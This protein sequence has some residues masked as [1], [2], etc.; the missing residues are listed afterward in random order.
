MGHPS[1]AASTTL[2][3]TLN[4]PILRLAIGDL[5]KFGLRRPAKGPMAQVVESRKIPL[6]DIGTVD[7]IRRRMVAV[8]PGIKRISGANVHFDDG[9]H[10]A[11]DIIIQATGYRPNLRPLLP[12]HQDVLDRSGGP[13]TCGN[14]TPHVGLFFCGY[15]PVTTGQLREIGLEAARIARAIR[16]GDG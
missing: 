14:T 2:V 6:L 13:L 11:F 5:E 8:R 15:I 7:R 1:A 16:V 12:D 10:E 4:A 9:T 3:D